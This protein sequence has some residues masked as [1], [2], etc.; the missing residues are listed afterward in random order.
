LNALLH[1]QEVEVVYEIV[2][3]LT[4]PAIRVT[5]Q[6]SVKASFASIQATLQTLA[7]RWSSGSVTYDVGQCFWSVDSQALPSVSFQF[8]RSLD[9]EKESGARKPSIDFTSPVQ[10]QKS[11]IGTTEGEAF[12]LWKQIVTEYAVPTANVFEI[13][14][15]SRWC[16]LFHDNYLRRLL[17]CIRFASLSI[18]TNLYN[19]ETFYTKILLYE[20]DLITRIAQLLNT[21]YD[22]A[23]DIHCNI[24]S[25]LD[26]IA[27]YRGKLTEVM[28][29]ISASANHGYLLATLRAVIVSFEKNSNQLLI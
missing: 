2:R 1:V 13:M 3:F 15:R 19:E 27:H 16:T 14:H 6:K 4:R 29:A 10:I 8:Y 26:S 17:L 12:N 24:I 22:D 9:D 7:D 28:S 11:P 21:S 5:S 20:P 25:L 18:L 23:P